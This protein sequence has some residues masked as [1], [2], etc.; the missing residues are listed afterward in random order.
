[1]TEP[2]TFDQFPQRVG[3]GFSQT[4]Q[5]RVRFQAGCQC[6]LLALIRPRINRQAIVIQTWRE[7][8]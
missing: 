6:Q 2:A 3:S 5:L 4:D 7:C 1:M 8:S